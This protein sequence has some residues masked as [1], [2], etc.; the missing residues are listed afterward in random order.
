MDDPINVLWAALGLAIA[1]E[2][3]IYALFPEAM[4]RMMA[5]VMVQP[6]GSIRGAGIGAAVAGVIILWLVQG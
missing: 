4:K 6:T 5:M 1:I 3:I 2:G